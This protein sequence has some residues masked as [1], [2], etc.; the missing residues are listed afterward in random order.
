MLYRQEK[1]SSMGL[2]NIEY[3]IDQYHLE[4][5]AKIEQEDLIR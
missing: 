1:E 3:M 2:L 5:E 4:K